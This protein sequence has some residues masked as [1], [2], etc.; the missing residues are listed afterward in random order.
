MSE[1][2]PSRALEQDRQRVLR[3]APNL[4]AQAQAQSGL[5]V[6]DSP[7]LSELADGGRILQ[8]VDHVV[9]VAR[10]GHRPRAE[11]RRAIDRLE[12]ADRIPY[13][14]VLDPRSRGAGA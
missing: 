3:N 12:R 11:L 9:L 10:V 5:V 8:A 1:L 14:G 2:H 7:P 13:G 6:V 4:I